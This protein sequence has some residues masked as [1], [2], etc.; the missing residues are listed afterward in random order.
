[1][2]ERM[3]MY[4]NSLFEEAP[5]NRK[6]VELEEEILQNLMD[7]YNDLLAEGKDE[8]AAYNIAVASIGDVGSL[9]EDLNRSSFPDSQYLPVEAVEKSRQRSALLTSVAIA[10]Y[11]LCVIPPI[12]FPGDLIGPVLLFCMVAAATGLLVYNNMTKV[13][14]HKTDDT[15]VEDFREWK[16]ENSRQRHAYQAISSALWALIS[17]IYIIVSFLTMAWHITWVIFL[18]GGAVNGIIK[19]I[20]D[21]RR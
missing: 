6:T 4:L 21:L 2:Q 7:K 12:L 10:L 8:E 3:R 18:I 14:Y 20:F 13:K 9:I 15:V 11:I 19:A 17:A 5:K 1:M 16:F